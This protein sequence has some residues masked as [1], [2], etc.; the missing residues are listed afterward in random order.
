MPLCISF[1]CEGL[2]LADGRTQ[3][4][5]ISTFTQ[6]SDIVYDHFADD[7][8]RSEL[9]ARFT[10]LQPCEIV[11]PAV[12]LSNSTRNFVNQFS[13][14]KS[15][16]GDCVRVEVAAEC[17]QDCIEDR[18]LLTQVYSQQTGV[19]EMIDSLPPVVQS[20]LAMAYSYLKSYQLERSFE[21]IR[22]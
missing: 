21:N 18:R 11:V 6:D 22:Y 5:I 20:C 2:E 13:G 14:Y 15:V 19:V 1:I 16:S 3:I 10:Q 17:S 12:G 8:C 4:G 9:D 7:R